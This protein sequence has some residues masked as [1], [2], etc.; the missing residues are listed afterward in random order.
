MATYDST[1]E[2]F[3]ISTPCETAQK[4][5]IGGAAMVRQCPLACTDQHKACSTCWLLACLRSPSSV[6]AL[7]GACLLSLPVQHANHTVAFA[8]LNINGRNEGVHAFI[9][10]IRDRRGR[11]L[12]NILIADCGHKI[13]L[14]GIDNGRIWCV[15]S[16]AGQARLRSPALL[17]VNS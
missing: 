12:P 17:G 7:R 2:E 3:I 8:Q 11:V 13:G 9:V 5:W 16:V 10:P 15:F 1:T 4:Y 14:N 6:Q